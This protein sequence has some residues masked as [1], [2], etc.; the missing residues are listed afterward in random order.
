MVLYSLCLSINIISILH[1]KNVVRIVSKIC[2]IPVLLVY[3]F[4]KSDDPSLIIM[5]ALAFSWSGDI[6]LINPQKI[7]LY[8]GVLN[9]FIAHI[10]YVFVFFVLISDF[11]ILIFVISLLLI[12]SVE[13]LILLKINIPNTHKFPVFIYGIALGLVIVIT[14]QVFVSHKNIIGILPLIGSVLFFVSDSVL[15][16][17]NTIRKMTK[18]ALAFV[19]LSYG[20]AQACIVAGFSFIN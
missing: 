13:Y 8:A 3:Y 10:L 1:E 5:L 6:L 7:R 19:M 9:F 11:N 20:I 16:Y 18:N 14:L 17:F 4:I 15:L 12:L 2:L